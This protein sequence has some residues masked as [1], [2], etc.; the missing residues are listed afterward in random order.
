[1]YIDYFVNMLDSVELSEFILLQKI[2][3]KNYIP[4]CIVTF[5]GRA[6]SASS[7]PIP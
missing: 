6:I 2:T 4:W 3:S 5:M 1:M 7:S